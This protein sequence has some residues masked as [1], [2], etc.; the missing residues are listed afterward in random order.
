MVEHLQ[1]R[2]KSGSRAS[3]RICKS[4]EIILRS[5]GMRLKRSQR[6]NPLINYDHT[7]NST[8]PLP[9]CTN[10]TVP[11]TIQTRGPHK[12]P[13]LS[14]QC[15]PIDH[16]IWQ[17]KQFGKETRFDRKT[18]ILLY[19]FVFAYLNWP[20][21]LGF[22]NTTTTLLPFPRVFFLVF[23]YMTVQWRMGCTL[24]LVGGLNHAMGM[25]HFHHRPM[26]HLTI[27]FWFIFMVSCVSSQLV[28]YIQ[29]SQAHVG[30]VVPRVAILL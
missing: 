12:M 19:I 28:V 23:Y 4:R 29:R 2:V 13:P 22:F 27:E 15:I 11:T 16:F 9:G 5:L 8:W 18:T 21:G 6:E 24:F 17:V 20:L 7:L 14:S 26:S 30:K 1:H 10:K 25:T 3:W